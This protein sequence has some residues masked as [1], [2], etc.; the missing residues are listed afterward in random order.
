M[1][2]AIA[3]ILALLVVI[4]SKNVKAQTNIFPKNGAAGI[5]T[6]TPDA[7]SLL[8]IKS[9]KKGLLIPRM[10][11]NQRDAIATPAAG[12]LIYQTN[13]KPGFYY[14]DGSTWQPVSK[15]ST[16]QWITKGASIYYNAGNVGIGTSSP[17]FKLDVA[18]D[19]NI[20]SGN[21]LRINGIRVLRDNPGSGDNNVFLGDF[22]DTALS[23]GFRNTAMGSYSL[24]VNTGSYNTAYGSTSLK[25]NTTG[26]SNTAIGEKALQNNT[27]GGNNTALG[28]GALYSNGSANNNT[29]VG[30]QSLNK[31]TS[32]DNTAV[33]YQSLFN[34]VDGYQNTAIGGKALFS[35]TS[36]GS[37]IAIGLNAL[38]L[39]TAGLNNIAT[40]VAALSNN[41]TGNNN[42]AYGYFALHSNTASGNVGVGYWALN[43]NTIGTNNTAI[44][45]SSLALN[46]SGFNN[47]SIGASALVANTTG[48]YNTALGSTALLN[49][50]TGNSNTAIGEKAMQSNTTGGSNTALGSGALQNSTS[51]NNNTAVGFQSLYNASSFTNNNTAI[52][53]QALFNTYGTDNTAIGYQ[54]GYANTSGA[55][56]I[57]VGEN[58]GQANTGGTGNVFMGI[59]AGSHNTTGNFNT[60]IGFGSGG[61]TN[62]NNANTFYGYG[63]GSGSNGDNNSFVGYF[64]K[65]NSAS[66]YNC[67]AFGYQSV[68]TDNSQLMLGAASLA[69]LFC[70]VALTV[71]SDGRYKRNITENVPGLLFINKL[72]PVTYHLNVHDIDQKLRVSEDKLTAGEVAKKEKV[73]YTGFVA[74]DVEKAA[75]EIGYDFSGVSK[76]ANDSDFY[77]IR[78]TDFIMPLVKAV[79]ELSAKNDSLVQV[80][81]SIQSQMNSMQNEI[82]M[83]ASKA[84]VNISGVNSQQATIRSILSSASIEQNV[85]N[86]YNHS[87]SIAYNL[88]AGYSSAQ[89]VVTD[90]TGKILKTFNVSGQGK[91]VLHLDGS[92][93]SAGAYN[94]SFYVN[95]KLIDSKKMQHIQ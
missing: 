13:A 73:L 9:T 83:L 67:S 90:Y 91:A 77:G 66:L 37:N 11:K 4:S 10:T 85:P 18:G 1:K 65:P 72:K 64:A 49:N 27:T 17:K 36:G 28:S 45:T 58:S 33:G 92:T 79:Q 32:S 51:S 43:S 86:P 78:Y 80:N 57:F 30:F 52:G 40:G 39:N 25:N 7:S 62:T 26:A 75:K 35:N 53:Y 46:T 63:S 5:G 71:F 2:K 29:A 70:S 12:L 68:A 76:P 14:N 48:A 23:P 87:T 69:K 22:A 24:S 20:A 42:T 93:L 61:I 54:A 31:N 41:T 3:I 95:G 89:I 16:S 34:N 47:T 74:Q 55:N 38:E 59:G 44:G 15:S 21:Y 19:I 88:P 56:N 82:Q 84:G 60:Y 94:Y 8:E 6:T 50:T 81:A